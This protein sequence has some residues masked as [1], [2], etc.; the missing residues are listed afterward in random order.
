[1]CKVLVTSG[2][3]LV[4]N[5]WHHIRFALEDGTWVQVVSQDKTNNGTRA[6]LG[7]AFQVGMWGAEV[8]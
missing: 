6:E 5:E 1:M 8:N 2:Y 7:L 4:F 3:A